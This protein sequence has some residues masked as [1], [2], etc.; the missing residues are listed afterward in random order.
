SIRANQYNV[1]CNL[2]RFGSTGLLTWLSKSKVKIGF[3]KNPFAF[4]F[5]HKVDHEIGNGKHE[6]ERNFSLL[7]AYD[8]NGVLHKP[9]LY[10]SLIQKNKVDEIVGE[11]NFYVFAPS[12]VWFTKQLPKNKWAELLMLKAKKGTLYLIGAPNDKPLL[13]EIIQISE[14]DSC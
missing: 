13:D 11:T 14:L 3:R 5:T 7:L 9:K 8:K 6:I 4:S 12:S 10:P 1:I 2:Q